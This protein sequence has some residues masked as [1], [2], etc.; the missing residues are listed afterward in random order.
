VP[1][2]ALLR[3]WYT[4]VIACLPIVLVILLT[5]ILFVARLSDENAAPNDA[6]SEQRGKPP[7]NRR[8]VRDEIPFSD[9]LLFLV[10]LGAMAFPILL[11]RP[12]LV[13]GY[14]DSITLIDVILGSE[15]ALLIMIG[16]LGYLSRPSEARRT[17]DG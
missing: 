17:P 15:L 10:G 16:T 12:I 14:V 13:P 6:V 4:F 11:L 2:T 9:R 5:D 8:K 1:R 7:A 3:E